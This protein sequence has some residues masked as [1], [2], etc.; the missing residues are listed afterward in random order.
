[1]NALHPPCHDELDTIWSDF[2]GDAELWVA[3]L[4]ARASARSAPAT[5]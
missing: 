1:M 2:A 3:I 5:T 4:T